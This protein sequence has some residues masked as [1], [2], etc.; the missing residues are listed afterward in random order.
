M[1]KKCGPLIAL[2]VLFLNCGGGAQIHNNTTRHST[3]PQDV[4]FSRLVAFG[5]RYIG[6]YIQTEAGY[7]G[8]AAQEYSTCPDGEA[9]IF[10]HSP[11]NVMNI[12]HHVC[13]PENIAD[14]VLGASIGDIFSLS[15]NVHEIDSTPGMSGIQLRVRSITLVE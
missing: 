13:V 9:G 8:T 15:A 12:I 2:A 7:A 3:T 14:P 5:D 1:T 10:L 4:E 6:Q 11:E